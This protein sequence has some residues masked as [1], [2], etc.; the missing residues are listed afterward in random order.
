MRTPLA[1]VLCF[2]S[3][4]VS[5]APSLIIVNGKI[6]DV[7]AAQAIAIE[8][9]KIT[10][11][12]TNEQVRA[13]AD[14]ST[15]VIDAAARLVIP[16]INDAHTHPGTVTPSFVATS[17]IEATA[18]N[19]SAAIAAAA[20]ESAEDIWIRAE[21]GPAVV[22][23]STITRETLDRIAPKRKVMITSFTGHGAV[24]STA[25]LADL[26]IALDSPDPLGGTFGRGADGKLNGRVSEY[27]QY[28]IDRRF[29]SLAS[30]AELADGI[31]S[32]AQEAI[33]F[34]IT[35][36]QAMPMV[37]E[38]AFAKAVQ[39]A[40]TPLRIRQITFPTLAGQK[41]VFRSGGGLKWI[42]D[43]TPIEH[44]AALRTAKYQDGTQGR[45]N[46]RD[47][48]PLVKLAADNN[49]QLLVHAAGDKAVATALGA[50]KRV[51]NLKRPRI[52]H[53]DGLQSDLFEAARQV[54]AVVVLNPT[55]FPFR[56][57]YPANQPYMLAASI[58]NAKIPIALGSDG[59]LNPYLNIMFAASRPD[60]PAEALTREEA[61]RAYTSGSAF[62]ESMETQK[63]KI[64]PGMLADLAILSQ[65]ILTVDAGA[66]P[67]TR[68]D[69]TIINGKVVLE[70]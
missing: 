62:A 63:G 65:D 13:L 34:G 29:A 19:V 64:A 27:A 6:F 46:F 69:V 41:P 4:G 17:D 15:R 40:N 33:G 48:L 67:D 45:E 7:P 52:E 22:N 44:G 8:G 68:A 66:L 18:A 20:D 61:L 2:V 25:A 51:G 3:L 70:R 58:K 9:N 56:G 53:G 47:F 11:V 24:L 50:M 31:N 16:G 28:A 32:F 49:Q 60:A 5:A 55:H 38:D 10:A 1:A 54:G 12:G 42:L 26:G 21:V 23:D 30:A 36:V 43:G 39:R 59:P 57:F 14:A 35:S 37:D